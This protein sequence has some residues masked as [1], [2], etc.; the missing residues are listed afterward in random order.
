MEKKSYTFDEIK[1]KLVNYCVYQER[2]HAEVEQKMREFLLIDEAKE[3]I[4]LFL[5]K[6]NFLNEERFTRSYIRGKFYIKHWGKTKIKINLKQK[7][8]SERLISSCFDE[9]DD[10]DYEKTIRKIFDDYYT[11]QT[12]LKE[13]QKKTKTIKYLMSK[14]FEY[15]K[16]IDI[17]G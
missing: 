14:G 4:I 6:E 9:I 7:Q 13:Y 12:G 17:F 15:E 16:I 3:E 1:Q 5:L 8:I 2:C 11:K 10:S